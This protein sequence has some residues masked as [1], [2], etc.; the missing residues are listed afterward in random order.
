[1]KFSVVTISFN[2]SA[3]L[4]RCI[5]SVIGQTGVDIEYI[6]CDPG[7]TDGSRE[8]IERYRD[9]FAAVLLEP[10]KGPADGLNR[11]FARA[12][13]DVFFYLNS[14]DTIEPGAFQT[15]A[16]EFARDP[17][18]DMLCGHAWVVDENDR[19]LRRVWSDPYNRLSQ[20]YSA[21]IQ[22]QPSTYIRA[23]MF[24]K[25]GGFNIANRSNW[26]GE[27]F[28]DMCLAGARTK[29]IDSFMSNYRV[30]S[31]SITGT[32][33]DREKLDAWRRRCFEKL[34][35]REKTKMDSYLRAFWLLRR[36]LRNP[37]AFFERL[38]HGPVTGS[39]VRK[40]DA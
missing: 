1:M 12:T 23:A 21:S 4:E 17:M 15:A 40:G 28:V 32:G 20:A 3:F 35:G 29:V 34:M 2:Q 18:L 38:L 36:Q 6:I 39:A 37:P 9:A 25:A 26:D 5:R 11:G 8:I 27:L 24:R 19:R 30:H 31:Q 33:G 13:G 10:D 22:I 16:A 7:S 14:D